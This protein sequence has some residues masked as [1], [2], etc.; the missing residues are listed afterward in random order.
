MAKVLERIKKFVAPK[1]AV[2]E[3]ETVEVEL[4]DDE[5]IRHEPVYDH[6]T[7]IESMQPV[8]RKKGEVA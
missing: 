8:I 1:P 4:G 6:I 3:T 2:E 7:G 5:E